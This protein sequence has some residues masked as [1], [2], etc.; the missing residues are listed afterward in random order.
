M[1][2]QALAAG[3]GQP[4]Q[5]LTVYSGMDADAFLNPPRPREEVRR[6][7]GLADDDIA[8][9]TVARL[10]ELKGHDDIMAVA[11]AVLQANPKVRFVWIGDGILR[12]RLIAELER[13]GYPRRLHSYRPGAA[14]TVF[15]SCSAAS[16][17]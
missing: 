5:F 7:L 15:P 8:F 16:M 13:L 1:T 10:F 6:E 17:P 14:R 2:E 3:V 11:A 4:R 12:D 9:A